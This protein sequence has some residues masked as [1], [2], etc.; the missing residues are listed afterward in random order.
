[1]NQSDI[2]TFLKEQQKYHAE[3]LS[4]VRA[5]LM[6]DGAP[7]FDEWLAAMYLE[8][9]EALKDF[10]ALFVEY[11]LNT[12]AEDLARE[13]DGDVKTPDKKVWLEYLGVVEAVRVQLGLTETPFP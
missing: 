6:G 2:N 7:T 13:A 8:Q 12:I 5:G 11:D 9:R 1:M 4:A 10:Y 3:H